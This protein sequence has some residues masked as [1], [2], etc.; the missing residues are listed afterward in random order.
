MQRF[1]KISVIAVTGSIIILMML[2]LLIATGVLNSQIAKTASYFAGKAVKGKVEI[3]KIEGNLFSN[4]SIV[5]ISL[6]HEDETILRI[7]SFEINYT[8][9]RIIQK[10]IVAGLISINGMHLSLKEDKNGSWNFQKLLPVSDSIQQT[11]ESKPLAWHLYFPVI[12]LNNITVD[13]DSNNENSPVP[14]NTKLNALLNFEY[15]EGRLFAG[16]AKFNLAT[17]EPE[18]RIDRM[19]IETMMADSVFSWKGFELDM[20]VT[21]LISNGSIPLKSIEQSEIYLNLSPL[22]LEDLNGWIKG[23]FGNP[24]ITL[25]VENDNSPDSKGSKISFLIRENGQSVALNANILKTDKTSAYKIDLQAKNIDGEHWT[26]KPEMHS[27]ISGVMH[28]NGEGFNF[29][30]NNI[31]LN[32]KFSGFQYDQYSI[33]NI[34]LDLNK[35]GDLFDITVNASTP[36]GKIV[37]DINLKEKEY[38]IKRINLKHPSLAVNIKG[39]GNLEGTHNLNLSLHLNTTDTTPRL[40]LFPE[41]ISL[42]SGLEAFLSGT[43]DS[44][45]LKAGLTIDTLTAEE[46]SAGNLS[47]TLQTDFSLKKPASAN[48][49]ASGNTFFDELIKGLSLVTD[50]STGS[51]AYSKYYL[52]SSYIHLEKSNDNAHGL[53]TAN[54]GAGNITT[55]FYISGIFDNPAFRIDAS[56]KNADISKII[57]NE[58]YYTDLNF[59]IKVEGEGTDPGNSVIDME[60]ISYGSSVLGY[61]LEDFNSSLKLKNNSYELQGLKMETP[62]MFAEIAGQ[63]NYK[64]NNNLSF[65][66]QTKDA[67]ILA[68]MAGIESPDLTGEI[69]GEVSGPADS[70]NITTLIDLKVLKAGDL[71]V[72]KINASAILNMKDSSWTGSTRLR[73]DN[74]QIKDLTIKQ[75]DAESTFNKEKAENTISFLSS[76]SLKGTLK[77]GLQFTGDPVLTV[78]ELYFKIWDNEWRTTGSPSTVTLLKDSLLFNNIEINSNNSFVKIDGTLAVRGDENFNAELRDIKLIP[79]PGIQIIPFPLAGTVNGQLNISGKAEMPVVTL[80]VS[81]ENISL[82]NIQIE[83]VKLDGHYNNDRIE[84]ESYVDGTGKRFFEANGKLPVKISLAEREFQLLKEEKIEATAIIDQFDLSHIN[85]FIPLKGAEAAGLFSVRTEIKN[86]LDDPEIEGAVNIEK[87]AFRYDRFGINYKDVVMNSSITNKLISLDNLNIHAGRGN[88]SIK[89][90]LEPDTLYN[91]S[92]NDIKISITGNNFRPVDS[93]LLRAVINTGIHLTGSSEKLVIGG[94][95]IIKQANLNTDLFLKEFDRVSDD[96]EE[97]LLIEA[98]EQAQKIQFHQTSVPDI[99][100]QQMSDIMKNLSGEFDVEIPG[101]TWIK[102][103]NMNFEIN[104]LVKAVIQGRQIDLFGSMNVKRGYYKLYGKRLDFEEGEVTLTGGEDIDPQINFNIAYRFRDV[105]NLLRKLNIKVTG[106]VSKPQLSFSL[107]GSPIEEKDAISYLLFNKSSNQLDSRESSSIGNLDIAR[108]LALGQLSNVVKDALQ[109]SFGLDVIE[110]SGED[111]WTRGSVSIG[112]YITNNLFISYQ[113]TFALDKKNKQIEPEKI[114][115]EYQL[116]KSLFLQATNQGSD[117]GFDFIYKWTWK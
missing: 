70:L 4:F 68:T 12:E 100:K 98:R 83:E 65:L 116:L 117:S 103:K 112:R 26:G 3:G 56:L 96:L 113:R 111:G 108:D 79:V 97:P 106:K 109:S 2:L 13:V 71:K 30:E 18:L 82:D 74:T 34:A 1:I 86:R 7:D 66:L 81:A 35:A 5:D 88:L 85:P 50:I 39:Q 91:G 104:G 64:E 45:Y 33:D 10:N 115:L 14:E 28:I 72:E 47:A 16:M 44:L 6:K 92:F 63:G 94:K 53:I 41:N 107:D 11:K 102:G 89:G 46:L 61:K 87:G 38:Q 25:S 22:A 93:D 80:S 49:E 54:S 21:R 60:L 32:A 43:A 42:I 27:D 59:D 51:V 99:E 31:K 40:P 24:E 114:S 17:K 101:N 8:P 73:L 15:S 84:V 19:T 77:T 62:F 55:N 23:V 48:S 29:S 58:S 57:S 90:S 78:Q 67:G 95:L 105:E 9:S 37:S 69:K 36:W 20:P 75:F 76:D 110:I 52:D